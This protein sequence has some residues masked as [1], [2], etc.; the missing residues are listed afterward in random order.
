M[1][2]ISL[3]NGWDLKQ[4]LEF[5]HN[6]EQHFAPIHEWERVH[7]AL[8]GSVL[9]RGW[10]EKDLDII[11]LPRLLSVSKGWDIQ[12]VIRVLEEFLGSRLVDIK[13]LGT[14]DDYYRDDKNV[15]FTRFKEGAHAG[16][17][18]DFFFLS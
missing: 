17:R 9:H 16:R 1:S 14:D 4:G 5:V 6:L 3:D 11:V 18:V 8:G 13:T 12:P 15:W 10:S 2:A 7:F